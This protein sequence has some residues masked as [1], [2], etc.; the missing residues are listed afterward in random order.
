MHWETMA[1]IQRRRPGSTGEQLLQ[2]RPPLPHEDGLQE[3]A[4]PRG[5]MRTFG[6]A[7]EY[8]NQGRRWVEYGGLWCSRPSVRAWRSL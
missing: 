3:A 1:P 8:L 2:A 6:W 4:S 5:A 7:S